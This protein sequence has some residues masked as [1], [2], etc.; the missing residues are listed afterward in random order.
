MVAGACPI[1]AATIDGSLAEWTSSTPSYRLGAANAAYMAPGDP[2]P[3][4]ADLSAALWL[5]CSGNNLLAAGIITD[6]VVIQGVGDI[7]V[8][9][10]AQLG[11]D[12]LNDKI[13]R[14]GQDDQELMV[15]PAG[16]LENYRRPIAGATVQART[17]PGSNWRFE[18]SVPLSALW[19]YLGDGA[20]IG[21]LLGL[22]DNDVTPTPQPSGTPGPDSVDRILIG[23]RDALALPTPTP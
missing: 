4:A 14:P 2:T 3:S 18:F 6:S 23:P 11:L 16:L 21:Y 1:L 7:Y 12:M 19:P 17:T 13:V 8:G 5:A 22:W 10:A 9:D 20:T 15:N